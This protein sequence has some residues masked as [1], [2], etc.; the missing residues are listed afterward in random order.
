VPL[1]DDFDGTIGHFDGGL[2]V[3]QVRRL[4]HAGGPFSALAM[5]LSG[6]FS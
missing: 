3:N 5:Q 6:I 2:I 1:G 4:R